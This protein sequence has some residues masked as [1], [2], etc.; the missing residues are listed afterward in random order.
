[1]FKNS[2]ISMLIGVIFQVSFPGCESPVASTVGV[3]SGGFIVGMK[4]LSGNAGLPADGVSKATIRIEVFNSAGQ[5]V[6]GAEVFI[7]TTLGTLALSYDANGLFTTSNGVALATLTSGTTPGT[8]FIV[9]TVENVS[10]T[11][12]VQIVNI[13]GTVA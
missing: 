10:A 4:A 11:V 7:T 3:S 8:A 13:S 6:D 9:A 5:I 1:M 2:F 12:A